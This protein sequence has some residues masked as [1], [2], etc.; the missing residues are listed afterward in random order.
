MAT[1]KITAVVQTGELRPDGDIIDPDGIDWSRALADG[2]MYVGSPRLLNAAGHLTSVRTIRASWWKR[3][4]YWL[5]RRRAP[6][7]VVAEGQLYDT[8]PGRHVDELIRAGGS[9]SFG[10]GGTVRKRTG[11]VIEECDVR[12]VSINRED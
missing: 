5:R 6:Q 3:L 10:I 12:S 1:K 7:K 2:F 4:W 11:N 8:P 9:V